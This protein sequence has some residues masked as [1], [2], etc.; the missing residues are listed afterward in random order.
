MPTRL[1][2]IEWVPEAEG[3]QSTDWTDTQRE[4][5][6]IASQ[7]PGATIETI[8]VGQTLRAILALLKREAARK[9]MGH[10]SFKRTTVPD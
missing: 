8:E 1:Y 4:A 10:G 3:L 5:R 7:H 6:T 9:P 2:R